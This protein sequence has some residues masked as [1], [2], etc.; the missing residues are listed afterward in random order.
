MRALS[1]SLVSIAVS[2]VVSTACVHRTESY[3]IEVRTGRS[4]EE[5]VRIAQSVVN[6]AGLV[7][8]KTQLKERLP[9]VTDAQL[10]K[11]GIR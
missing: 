3:S 9:G 11:L 6:E 4:T 2:L 7:R 5:K 1:S 10:A 8:L